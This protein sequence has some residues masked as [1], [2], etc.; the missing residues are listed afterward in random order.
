MSIAEESINGADMSIAEERSRRHIP[1]SASIGITVLLGFA[2]VGIASSFLMPFDPAE[3]VT[4]EAFVPPASG[5][6]LG[7]DSLGRDVLSRLID[8]T[9][10][11]IFMAFA[12]TFLAHLIGDSLGLLAAVK[13]GWIDSALSRAVDVLLS[14][15]KIIVGLVVLAALGPS[16]LVII[17]LA[18]IVYSAGVFRIARA[19]G[20][21]VVNMDY[22]TV[23]RS[24]GESLSWLLF[25]EILP[26][27][28]K[29]LAADFVMRMS[30]AILFMSSL[31]F[32]G[33]GIQPPQADWGGMA[34]DGMAGLS[35]NPY[36]ALAP[37]VCIALLS[38]ALN[39]VVD[40]LDDESD[41]A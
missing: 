13:G 27:V 10:I 22:I 8:A 11:T 28:V 9:R 32:I 36:A 39:L 14:L 24:R 35:A 30:F 20:N 21:D 15:P 16:P 38:I 12:A 23:V 31:S 34:R 3:F 29:P 6:W 18:A 37:A 2:I 26:N 25:G 33:L 1:L 19:L 41:R 5:N 17:G 7:S 4:D 40:A